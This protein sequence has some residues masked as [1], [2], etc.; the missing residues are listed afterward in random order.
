MSRV[1]D[2]GAEILRGVGGQGQSR[3]RESTLGWY[4]ERYGWEPLSFD[5]G[6]HPLWRRSDGQAM[7]ASKAWEITLQEIG[8]R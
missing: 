5:P 1:W 6:G 7:E 2:E 8:K 3:Y 4:L